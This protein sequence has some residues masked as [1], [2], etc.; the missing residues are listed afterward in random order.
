MAGNTAISKGKN[1]EA[2]QH[3]TDAI[4]AINNNATY[5]S[6]RAQAYINLNN[7]EEAIKDA[8]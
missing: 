5:F 8:E 4:E 6:N 7:N 2:V 3:Y 1:K